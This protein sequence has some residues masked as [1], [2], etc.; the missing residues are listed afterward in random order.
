MPDAPDPSSTRAIPDDL[1]PL[2]AERFGLPEARHL[3]WRAGF[4]GTSAQVRTLASWGL[5]RAVEHIVEYDGIAFDGS[6]PGF[7]GT[8]MREPSE[9]ERREYR[10][11]LARG[12]EDVVARFRLLR[13]RAQG[14]DRRQLREVQQWWLRRMIETPRPLEEKLTLMWHG[15]FA[16][17][18]RTI[19]NS[20][21][22]WMQNEFLRANAAGSFADLLHGIVRDPA[23]LAY[24]DQNDSRKNR[25]NENLARELMELFGLGR[26]NYT[27]RD[28]K[29]GARALTG[30]TFY[31]NEFVFDRQNHDAGSKTILG[32]R[33]D[34]DGAGF[35]D[36]IL[37]RPAC[38][39]LVARRLYGFFVADLPPVGTEL[40]AHQTG[41]IRDLARTLTRHRYEL[42]PALT[43]L[44]SSAH[45]HDPAVMGSRIKSPA[46]LVVGAVRSLS[47]PVRSTGVL[48][49]A[50]DLM[51]QHLLQ[52]PSVKGWDG[53]RAWINTSTLYVRQNLLAFLLTGAKPEGYGEG[54]E[55]E[56]F[57]P[58]PMLREIAAADPGAER[59]AGRLVGHLMGLTLLA[60]APGAGERLVEFVEAHGGASGQV[61]VGALLLITALPEYQL[62]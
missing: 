19:E 21:H 16:T 5:E 61:V 42:R 57:D 34:F 58:S 43:R 56:I 30:H 24:L 46:E 25:P 47:T 44:F 48:V 52:P 40:P 20:Y 17:G 45:F 14:E 3:L 60:P 54:A 7:A 39:E 29:E 12:D 32:R 41:A 33:G 6:E 23:M 36:L 55:G 22:M 28:I 1:A 37:S 59:D 31:A 9:E 27:E 13:Q 26:G 49:D 4:G 51:G 8:I 15:H 35:V 10:A 62:V 11:A 53:G 18:Y 50:M 38:A 2:P